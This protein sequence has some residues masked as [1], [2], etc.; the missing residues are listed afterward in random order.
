ML[1]LGFPKVQT[2]SSIF[3]AVTDKLLMLILDLEKVQI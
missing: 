1:I 2:Y 3:F